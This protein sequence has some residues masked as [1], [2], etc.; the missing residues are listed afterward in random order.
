M[1]PDDP[2]GHRVWRG[3]RNNRGFKLI[4]LLLA[5]LSWYAIREFTS[6]TTV[7][8]G[9]HVRVL[10]DEG[11]AVLDRSVED[12]DVVCRGS[13]SDIRYLNRD[14]FQVEVDLRSRSE[15]GTREIRLNPSSIKVPGGARAIN[16]DPPEITLTLDREGE[17]MVAAHAEIVGNPPDGYEVAEVVCTPSEV[18]LQ[19]PQ[20][21][22]AGMTEVKT[23]QIDLE[24][25][26]K[27]FSL[28]RS[29]QPPS[30]LWSARVE[31]DR[32]RVDVRI[33]ERSSS[34][35]LTDIPVLLLVRPDTPAIS[36]S[37]DIPMVS[38][39]LRGR[40]ESL[41]RLSSTNLTAFIDCRGLKP[42][43]PADLPITVVPIPSS[44]TIV[45]QQ[46]SQIRV[47]LPRAIGETP[48]PLLQPDLR[49][50]G[51]ALKP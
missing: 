51:G 14:Q 1:A 48:P 9:V 6:F 8:R 5:I 31:P 25:R 7:V 13:Q 27:S 35:D 47:E 2:I 30:D 49:D 20:G 22:L 43:E 37:A 16:I 10:V 28:T 32:V 34:L 3:M 36:L 42:G 23:A 38:I 17:R 18:K 44:V 19:G 45:T 15:S 26:L 12:V 50:E 21:R 40:A 4:A 33:V 39:S 24:G 41:S 11:W 29:L 46:P